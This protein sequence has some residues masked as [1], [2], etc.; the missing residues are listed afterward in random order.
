MMEL[1]EIERKIVERYEYLEGDKASWEEIKDKTF[2]EAGLDYLD[3]IECIMWAEDEFNITILNSEVS[4]CV[5]FQN[6]AYLVE[7]KC[8]QKAKEFE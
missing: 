5:T 2:A 6:F 8:L 1:N 3:R 4:S 7:R